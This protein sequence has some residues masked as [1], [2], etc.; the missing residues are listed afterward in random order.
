ME[1]NAANK[2]L[3]DFSIFVDDFA[4]F[5]YANVYYKSLGDTNDESKN[6][7]QHPKNMSVQLEKCCKC[8]VWFPCC[9][10][11]HLGKSQKL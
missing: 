6:F 9:F 3:G 10:P 2:L 8:H 7:L 5:C 1:K 4:R 11:W